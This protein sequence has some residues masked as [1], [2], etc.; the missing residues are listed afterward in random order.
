MDEFLRDVRYG[1]RL[2]IKNPGFSC[3]ALITLALGIG[4]TTAIFSV[5]SGVLLRPLP[6]KDP[7]K[8]VLIKE[9]LPKIVPHP[10]EIPAPDVV[11][12]GRDARSFEG[13]AG[14]YTATYDLTGQGEPQRVHAA[15]V[16]WNLIELLGV[17]PMMGRSFTAAEDHPDSYV[18][19]VSHRFWKERMGSAPDAVGK[20]ITLDRKPFQ[21]IGVMPASFSFPL[22]TEEGAAELWV[23]MGFTKEELAAIG[24]NFGYGA[25]ARLKPGVSIAQATSDV[26]AIAQ[27]I[28]AQFPADHARDLQMFGV[29]VPLKEDAV[30]A[31][32]KPLLILLAAVAFVLLIAVVNVANL[33]LARGSGR[34]R[35]LSIRAALGAGATRIVRQLLIES[36][37]LGLIGGAAGLVLAVAATKGLIVLVPSN[38][39]G[40]RTASVDVPVLLFALAISVVA[41]LAFGAAPAVFVLKTNLSSSLKQGGRGSTVG[42]HQQRLRS[43]FVVA[44]VALALM[45][46]AGAGLLLRSFQRVLRVDPGFRPERVMTAS[47]SLSQAQ[48]ATPEQARKFHLVGLEKL[49]TIPGAVATGLSSDLPLNSRSKRIFSVDGYAEA[50]GAPLHLDA[51]SNVAGDYFQAM[52]IPLLRGRYFTPADEQGSNRVI[53]ISQAI[54]DEFF[55]GRDPIGGRI[56]W[57]STRSTDPWMTVVGVVGNVKQGS[58]DDK[59]LP[60]TYTP[61]LQSMVPE[62][63]FGTGRSMNIAVRTAGDPVSAATS[64]RSAIWSIDRQVPVTETRTME[65]VISE[66]TAT[67]RFNATLVGFFA[68][69]ALLLAAVGLYGVMAYSVSQRT[70]EIGVRMTLGASRADVLRMVLGTGMKLV[71]VGV[72][73]GLLAAAFAT[74]LLT[75][76]LFD[77]KAS[78]P[79]T[80]AGVC[81]L[82]IG[83]AL[84]ASAVPAIRATK[85]DPVIALRAE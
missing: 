19:V 65:Q 40:L 41:G 85:V 6:F 16:G 35:E 84:M 52:G 26:N 64:M 73:A 1:F 58:L 7:D 83:I 60:H 80:F 59:T 61:V 50:P 12:Y 45:L 42:R 37:V 74:R 43:G 67:R 14:F 24:D 28:L 33:L 48:Y 51:H 54:A 17:T 8:L 57:G 29:V 66:S 82:L 44:Q 56:K 49:R 39:P 5:V 30:G 13:V 63:R 75:T 79:V 4:A 47:I 31:V 15:R 23:P 71:C 72:G 22:V 3:V 77:V 11:T 70:H 62:W 27:Q 25:L 53:I 36:V 34:M 81:L 69:A 55:A 2:L 68:G 9:R 76:F 78:D 10:I 21:V 18:A 46:L 38:I 32:R 20:T